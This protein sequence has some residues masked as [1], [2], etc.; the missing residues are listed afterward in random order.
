MT[1]KQKEKHIASIIKTM[2]KIN[3]DFGELKETV[4]ALNK[5][6]RSFIKENK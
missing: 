1:P 3:A 4:T 6:M 5:V 2:Q